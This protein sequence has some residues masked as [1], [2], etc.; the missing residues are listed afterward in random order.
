MNTCHNGRKIFII[1]I[2][3]ASKKELIAYKIVYDITI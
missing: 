1:Y 3:R 2:I